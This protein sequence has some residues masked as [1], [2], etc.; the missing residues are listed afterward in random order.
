MHDVTKRGLALAVATGGLLITGAAPALSAVHHPEHQDAVGTKSQ[1]HG[2]SHQ[3]AH[4]ALLAVS[5]PKVEYSGRHKAPQANHTAA[6]QHGLPPTHATVRPAAAPAAEQAPTRASAPPADALAAASGAAMPAFLPAAG[7]V[8]SAVTGGGGGVLT[9]NVVEAPVHAPLNV[10]G[11]AVTGL[12]G[13]NGAS[14]DICVNGP[15]VAGGTTTSAS[16]ATGGDRGALND[17]V[18]QVPVT[19]PANV[20]GDTVTV[21]GDGDG[22]RDILCANE[23]PATSS[24]AHAHTADADGIGNANIVQVPVDLPV[25]LC[26]V[27]ANAVGSHDPAADVHC[28]NGGPAAPWGPRVGAGAAAAASGSSGIAD[29]NIVQVPV[30]APLDVCGDT[31]NVIGS[32]NPAVGDLCVN[33][34]AGGAAAKG[35]ASDDSGLAT[36]NVAQVPIDL[37]TE[38]CGITAAVAGGFDAAAGDFCFNESAPPPCP[39]LPPPCPPPPCPPPPPSCTCSPP[40]NQPPPNSP[41]PPHT[42]P[43]VTPPPPHH[44]APQLPHTGADVLGL[45]GIGAGALLVGAGAVVATRRKSGSAN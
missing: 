35:I 3:T 24:T 12:G 7:A 4:H 42:P 30:Q 34:T 20:C 31:L 43:P 2:S 33:H 9:G 15:D 16:A 29:A 18:V 14:G 37:P 17:N 25:N 5:S 22:V 39:C 26:G 21:G 40:P 13:A 32:F 8:A 19:L 27:T 36:G 41:P 44:V 10:C 11:V 23:G 6:P 1:N 38:A 45:A 28:V